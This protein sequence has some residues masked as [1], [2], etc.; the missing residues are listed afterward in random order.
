MFCIYAVL[1][2]KKIPVPQQRF[3]QAHLDIRYPAQKTQS[4]N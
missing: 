4:S 1:L 3:I 2:R